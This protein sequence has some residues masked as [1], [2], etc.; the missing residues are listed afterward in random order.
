M[1]PAAPATPSRVELRKFVLNY[2]CHYCFVDTAKAFSK[3]V[4]LQGWYEGEEG[5]IRPEDVVLTEDHAQ[6]LKV[7]REIREDILSG[8]IPAA[9]E[10][11][12]THFPSVLSDDPPPPPPPTLPHI[13]PTPPPEIPQTRVIP[14]FPSSLSPQNISI[15]LSIQQWIETLRTVPLPYPASPSPVSPGTSV[16]ATPVLPSFEAQDQTALIVMGRQLYAR[17]RQLNPPHNEQFREELVGIASLIAYKEPEKAPEIVRHHLEWSRRKGVAT[18]VN[19]AILSSL[20]Y[21]PY[22]P[23][24]SLVRQLTF[25]YQMLHE[26]GVHPPEG[27]QLGGIELLEASEDDQD[28]AAEAIPEFRLSAYLYKDKKGKGDVEAIYRTDDDEDMDADGEAEPAPEDGDKDGE[29][30]GTMETEV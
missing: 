10:N 23:L 14:S 29:E 18:Q 2:L 30:E 25:V 27:G 21:P 9:R 8:K 1:A 13:I 19:S 15:T 5:G 4:P 7:R 12:T 22:V 17:A 11:I 24:A 3:C 20:G 16:T 28:W 26:L 6:Q